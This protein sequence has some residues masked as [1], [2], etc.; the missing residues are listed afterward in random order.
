MPN[1]AWML[2]NQSE[3]KSTEGQPLQFIDGENACKCFG[4]FAW[5]TTRTHKYIHIFANIKYSLF[6]FMHLSA[7]QSHAHTHT[8]R[9]QE[10]SLPSKALFSR[11]VVLEKQ[12]EPHRAS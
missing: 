7:T 1:T 10:T 6:F 12:R 11:G 8:L 3:K 9:R 5:H 2:I 4:A